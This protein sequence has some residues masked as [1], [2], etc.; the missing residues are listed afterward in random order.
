MIV[1]RTRTD[2][3][4]HLDQV[5]LKE[6]SIGF[7]PTMGALHAGHLSLVDR[8]RAE[9]STSVV[10]I[11]VNPTQFND[12]SDLEQ[13]PRTP[14]KDLEMLKQREVDIVFLPSV[15]EMYPEPDQR[16][17]DLGELDKV[18]EGAQRADHFNGVAQVV[19]ML[20]SIVKPHRAYFGRK[21]FQQLVIVRHLAESLNLDVEI[22]ACPIVREPDG[23]AMSSRNQRLG[24]AERKAAPQIYNILQQ[25]A[26]LRKDKTPEA[27]SSWVAMEIG[28]VP[29]MQLEYFEIVEDKGLTPVNDWEEKVNKVACIA[30]TLGGVR[31]ID[32]M[33]FD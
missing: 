11:F 10:S 3:S 27:L 30:V 33:I 12:P 17:F 13:Y 21:D 18:M 1:Y 4:R 29:G 16:V 19:T 26:L 5:R 20:F 25:A 2:L 32:N 6:S 31:L 7:V 9:N 14:E 23:L 28:K 8:S 22:I 24:K 15:G